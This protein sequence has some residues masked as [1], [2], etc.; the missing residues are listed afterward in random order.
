MKKRIR[1]AA[2]LT[3]LSLLAGS[4]PAANAYTIYEYSEGLAQAEESGRWGFAGGGGEI[5][6]PIQ[7]R[8]VASFSLGTAAVDLDGRLGVIRPDGEYLIQPE[9][10]TLMPAGYGLYMAQRADH[11]RGL[12]HPLRQRGAGRQRRSGRLDPHL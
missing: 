1:L 9:Y 3:S 12:S 2:A 7:Y 11:Q 8:S 4:L 10:D 5:V 6:I